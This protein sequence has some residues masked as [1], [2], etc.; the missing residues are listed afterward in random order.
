MNR[1]SIL[2]AAMIAFAIGAVLA[3][4]AWSAAVHGKKAFLS[5]GQPVWTE[6]PWPFGPDIWGRGKAFRCN[7]ADCN[8]EIHVYVRP[9]IGFC[10]C[11]T[12]ISDDAELERLGDLALLGRKLEPLS[13]GKP[14]SVAWMKGLSRSYSI[15][16]PGWLPGASA[17]T[18]AFHDRCDA[19]VA[20]ATV[21]NKQPQLSEAAILDLLKSPAVMGWLESTI[22][23]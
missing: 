13:V 21:R 16:E 22:G 23:L 19:I 12:G 8:A 9:K 14:V 6:V 1:R 10:N 2:P 4:I 3:P 17:I 20:M 18:I 15:V 7:S 11:A 5:T